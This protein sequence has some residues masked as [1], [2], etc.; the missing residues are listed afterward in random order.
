MEVEEPLSFPSRLGKCRHEGMKPTVGTTGS[1]MET[2]QTP[3]PSIHE[4][5]TS[6][7]TYDPCFRVCWK[8]LLERAEKDVGEEE[9]QKMP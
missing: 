2:P 9:S 3:C 8:R 6:L 4:P 5:L 1:Q 7:I